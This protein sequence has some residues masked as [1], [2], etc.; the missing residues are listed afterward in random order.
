MN[1]LPSLLVFLG[2]IAFAAAAP[3]ANPFLAAADDKPVSAKFK[4]TEWNDDIG[5]K[6]LPLSA[7]VVTTR[8]AQAP[9][10]SIFKISFEDIASHADPKREIG[11]VYFIATDN[12]IVLLN[13]EKPEAAAQKLAAEAK[14]PA[15]E[16]DYVRGINKG[17][18][19]SAEG[20]TE[21]NIVVKGERCTYQWSHNSGHFTNI[22]WQ[23]GV[24]LVEYAQGRGA[25]ADG[26]RLKREP[27][28]GKG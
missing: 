12:E 28:K 14:A 20:L 23:K 11:P 27:A 17:T 25:R 15:F 18:R 8:I 3:A 4:G 26:Y 13:E 9:W 7:R 16:S 1:R 5:P 21:T 10:G 6:D 2:C 19:K 22:V 24:G